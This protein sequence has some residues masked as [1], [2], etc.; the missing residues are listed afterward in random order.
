MG[1]LAADL[2]DVEGHASERSG[3]ALETDG[4]GLTRNICLQM[5]RRVVLRDIVQVG[6]NTGEA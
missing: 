3:V 5:L 6:G 4:A 2:H 1:I